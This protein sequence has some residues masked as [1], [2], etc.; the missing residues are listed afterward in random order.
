MSENAEVVTVKALSK[1][2]F[3]TDN[4]DGWYNFSEDTTGT[5]LGNVRRGGTYAVT[6]F[7]TKNGNK[8]IVT[9]NEA[10]GNGGAVA[11]V[12]STAQAGLKQASPS[13]ASD[14]DESIVRQVAAK[15]ASDVAGK[16]VATYGLGSEEAAKVFGELFKPLFDT[17]LSTIRNK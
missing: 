4:F 9:I 16:L 8:Q 11:D 5:E 6:S 13:Y 14:R 2:G 10:S 3:K 1:F 17:V 7:K 12:S 15:C